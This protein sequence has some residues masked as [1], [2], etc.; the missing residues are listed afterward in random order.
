MLI[1]LFGNSSHDNKINK[2]DTSIIVQKPYLR[3]DYMENKIEEDIDS[4]NQ[5]RIKNSPDPISIRETCS[6]HYVN[7]L[8]NDP[9]ILKNTSH[10]DLNDRNITNARFIQFNQPPRIGSHLTAKLYV[11]NAIGEPSLVRIN[12]DNIFN[13]NNL[14]NTSSI[15]LKTQAVDDNQVITKVYVDYLHIDNESN[16][17]DLG[18]S[19]YNEEVDLVKNI[20]DNNL[21][22]N[23]LINLEY[24]KVYRDPTSDNELANKK[25]IDDELD[26]NTILRL[27]PTLENCLKITVGNNTYN[28]TKFDE[29]PITEITFIRNSNTGGYVLPLWKI[30]CTD[31]NGVG[32]KSK[33]H[34]SNKIK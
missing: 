1:N 19:F 5:Y 25:H 22:D 27:N 29:T 7:N 10:I 32:K 34:Q 23:K 26:K 24:I 2:I 12:Q 20:Q 4:K 14:T 33:F 13:N 8:F 11:D 9:S 17:R 3:S 16:R 6:K 21:N 28:L 18:L 30:Y 15:I 31:K